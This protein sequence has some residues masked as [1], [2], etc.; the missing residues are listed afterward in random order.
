MRA[1]HELWWV[2]IVALGRAKHYYGASGGG[3]FSSEKA[4]RQRKADLLFRYPDAQVEVYRSQPIEWTRVD[5]RTPKEIERDTM[6]SQTL[7]VVKALS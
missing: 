4:A 3:K 5:T 7:K 6:I 1:P 2:D